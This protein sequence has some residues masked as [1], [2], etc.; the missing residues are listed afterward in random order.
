MIPDLEKHIIKFD[1]SEVAPCIHDNF[2]VEEQFERLEQLNEL[3]R[4]IEAMRSRRDNCIHNI[5]FGM[6]GLIDSI[7]ERQLNRIDTIN[8]AIS[9]LTDA[10]LKRTIG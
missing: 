8:R 2:D 5:N 3:L 10:Y 4:A 9:R 7:R 6:A 1:P